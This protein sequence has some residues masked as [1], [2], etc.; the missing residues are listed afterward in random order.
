I[1][2]VIVALPDFDAGAGYGCT[3]RIENTADHVRDLPHGLCS[4]PRDPDEIVVRVAKPI[5]RI[6]WAGR[7]GRSGYE[8]SFGRQRVWSGEHQGSGRRSESTDKDA[9]TD[10]RGREHGHLSS[11]AMMLPT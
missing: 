3:A 11:P 7:L 10:R 8:S 6:E 1:V 4:L 2:P 9:A 5:D